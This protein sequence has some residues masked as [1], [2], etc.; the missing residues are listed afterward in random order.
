M[1]GF[2]SRRFD[3]WKARWELWEGL[4]TSEHERGETPF[5]AMMTLREDLFIGSSIN[6]LEPFILFGKIS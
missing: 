1:E 4:I 5:S 3:I 2:E 6:R